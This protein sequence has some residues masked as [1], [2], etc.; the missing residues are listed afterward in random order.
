MTV[1]HFSERALR[2]WLG[3][4][5]DHDAAMLEML[6]GGTLGASPTGAYL[7]SVQHLFDPMMRVDALCYLRLSCELSL[8]AKGLLMMR[9]NDLAAPPLDAATRAS[10]DELRHLERNLGATGLRVLRPLLNA[11]GRDGWQRTLL[12]STAT[13]A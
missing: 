13:T 4:G 1:F 7:A 6:D 5:F 8:R 11:G 3:T 9:E 2:D 10:L 12:E